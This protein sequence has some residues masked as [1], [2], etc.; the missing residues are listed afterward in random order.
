ME[1]NFRDVAQSW[2]DGN[3]DQE[4]KDEVRRL[5]ETD[6]AGLEDAFYRNLEFGT[7]GL[8]GIMSRMC[9]ERTT[10]YACHTTAG[11][12]AMPL[13]TLRRKSCLQTASTCIFTTACILYRS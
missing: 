8:R 1:K 12:T 6:P 10:A 2:L 5:M 3:Y 7:G 11:T 9:R 13:R 4:T